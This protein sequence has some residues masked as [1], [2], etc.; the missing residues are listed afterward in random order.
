M[1]VN[2]FVQLFA[3]SPVVLVLIWI[4]VQLQKE[5]A[6]VRKARDGDNRAW[7]ERYAA[8]ADRVS[9]AVERLDLPGPK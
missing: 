9:Q 5:L 7:L 6:E 3:S 4:I 1:D 2:Q 8:L